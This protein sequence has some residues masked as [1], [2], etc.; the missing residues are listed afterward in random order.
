MPKIQKPKRRRRDEV[1]GYYLD[2]TLCHH[3]WS[4]QR[5]WKDCPMC[6]GAQDGSN[7]LSMP[8]TLRDVRGY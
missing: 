3:K 1:V 5:E 2:C 7:V 4:S 8:F 6:E